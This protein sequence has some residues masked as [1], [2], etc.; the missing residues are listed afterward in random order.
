VVD[1]T[2]PLEGVRETE[3]PNPE[4]L[5]VETSKPVGAVTVKLSV[6]KDPETEKLLASEGVLT[7]VKIFETEPAAPTE[8][9]PPP[10]AAMATSQMAMLPDVFVVKNHRI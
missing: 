7:T 3:D 8:G 10:P 6:S 1:A 5:A 9:V 4:P 2:V